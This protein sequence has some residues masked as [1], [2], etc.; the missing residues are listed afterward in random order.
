[1]IGRVLWKHSF[2]IVGFHS[3]LLLY[4]LL[5]SLPCT[6]FCWKKTTVDTWV[7]KTE[8][9]YSFRTSKYTS[10]ARNNH[11]LLQQL[12]Y[13]NK[14]EFIKKFFTI[15]MNIE[16]SVCSYVTIC[17]YQRSCWSRLS[18]NCGAKDNLLLH[19]WTTIS[20]KVFSLKPRSHGNDL[21]YKF[22]NWI[23]WAEFEIYSEASNISTNYIWNNKH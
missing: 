4:K 20:E 14:Y 6:H 1:M 17:S 15:T 13:K 8:I 5:I 19:N 22:S 2:F 7:F 9:A 10:Q 11:L 23:L 16:L 3:Q 12:F 18:V 21:N